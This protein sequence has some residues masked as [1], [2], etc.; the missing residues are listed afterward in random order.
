[1][2][3]CEMSALLVKTENISLY[4]CRCCSAMSSSMNWPCSTSGSLTRKSWSQ[5]RRTSWWITTR[6]RSSRTANL[7]WFPLMSPVRITD[8]TARSFL[9][10]KSALTPVFLFSPAASERLTQEQ[11]DDLIAWMKNTL[12]TR[13]TNIKVKNACLVCWIWYCGFCW[14]INWAQ[15]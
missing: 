2:A 9:L 11:A 6:R 10:H 3:E 15:M 12:G 1:M 4:M 7:V 14:L 13:V 8:V 5:L